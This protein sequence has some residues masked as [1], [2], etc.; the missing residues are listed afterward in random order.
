VADDFAK[1]RPSRRTL[2][3]DNAWVFAVLYYFAVI[4]GKLDN[5]VVLDF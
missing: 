1:I 2:A 3:D 4:G 5:I